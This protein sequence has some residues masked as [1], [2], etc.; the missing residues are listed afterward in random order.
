MKN[1]DLAILL[2]RER[3]RNCHLIY[4]LRKVGFKADLYEV[5]LTSAYL[6]LMELE[7]TDSIIEIIYNFEK[8]I[9][10]FRIFEFEV[11]LDE[12]AYS[13]YKLLKSDR[14]H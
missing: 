1:K 12:L 8:N 10:D 3:L 4:N 14:S 5:Q 13:L 11:E 6:K 7:E 2:I 9:S